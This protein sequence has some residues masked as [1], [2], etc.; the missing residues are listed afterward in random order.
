MC[1]GISVI[2][3]KCLCMCGVSTCPHECER[4]L[5]VQP[6]CPFLSWVSTEWF[7]SSAQ[8]FVKL[9]LE[10]IHMCVEFVLMSAHEYVK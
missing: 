8:E 5:V 3:L 6:K 7:Y 9:A 10:A 2:L 1:C 4:A